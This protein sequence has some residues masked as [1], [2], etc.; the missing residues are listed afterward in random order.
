MK[1]GR[2]TVMFNLIHG[3]LSGFVGHCVVRARKHERGWKCDVPIRRHDNSSEIR[4]LVVVVK[5]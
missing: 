5:W 2:D 1:R 4:T 3:G